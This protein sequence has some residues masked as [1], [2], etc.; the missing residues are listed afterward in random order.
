MGY[1]FA[2]NCTPPCMEAPITGVVLSG[3]HAPWVQID[4]SLD[5]R[6]RQAATF[7]EGLIRQWQPKQSLR[8]WWN[9]PVGDEPAD[10]L[11]PQARVR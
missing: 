3:H 1:P 8:E 11:S 4:K 6:A 9:H 7:L 2:T 5:W 10:A